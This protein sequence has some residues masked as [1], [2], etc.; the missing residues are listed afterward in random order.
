MC[1]TVGAAVAAARLLRLDERP[2]EHVVALVLLHADGL[3]AAFG[4]DGKSLRVGMAEAAGVQATQL[5]AA[6]ARVPLG[7]LD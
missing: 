1:G 2:A 5:V 4:S 3:R 7:V 6:G